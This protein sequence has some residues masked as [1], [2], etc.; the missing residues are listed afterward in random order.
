MILN[1]Y[2]SGHDK[3]PV[4]TYIGN[5]KTIINAISGILSRIKENGLVRLEIV[6]REDHPAAS[7]GQAP[8]PMEFLQ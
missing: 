2:T 1:C 7:V 4:N 8:L 3:F 6:M 5:E